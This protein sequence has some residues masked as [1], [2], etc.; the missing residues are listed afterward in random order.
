MHD[1]I[2][3][4]NEILYVICSSTRTSSHSFL[5]VITR[6]ADPVLHSITTQRAFHK[7]NKISIRNNENKNWLAALAGWW[8][9]QAKIDLTR[10]ACE[11]D[12]A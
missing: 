5:Q 2:H 4:R 10:K 11:N 12:L 3:E 8:D 9:A 7:I 1:L 6:P